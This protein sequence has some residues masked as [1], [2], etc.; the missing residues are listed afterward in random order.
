[1]NYKLHLKI[2]L[3]TT[4]VFIAGIF[5][6]EMLNK[7]KVEIVKNDINSLKDL[8][9]STSIMMSLNDALGKKV[10]C[11]FLESESESISE[12]SESLADKIDKLSESSLFKN[13]ELENAK[14]DY[15]LS[16]I[17]NWIYIEQIK[18]NC[19]SS[20]VTVLF[21][22]N[23]S[24]KDICDDESFYLSYYKNKEAGKLMVFM[25]DK[26]VDA[27]IIKVVTSNFNVTEVPAIVINSNKTVY[28]YLNTTSIEKELCSEFNEFS[29][30][31]QLLK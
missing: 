5:I 14:K 26:E 28:G 18:K 1:M 31:S 17:N 10:K 20:I 11:S 23:D 30:C 13:R 15:F 6:A 4:Y 9:T 3:I 2:F 12:Y 22:Y 7:Q 8:V 21:F 25:I 19:N 24:C 29:F 16:L 27:P